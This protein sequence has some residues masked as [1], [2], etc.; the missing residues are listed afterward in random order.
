MYV[1]VNGARLYFD[2]EGAGLVPDGPRMREKPTLL[3]LHG[4][5]GFDHTIYK[6][7]FSAL[8]DIAQVIYLDH[9]G[10]GRSEG[11]LGR[12]NLPQWGDDVKGFCDALGIEKPIVYGASFGG[13]VAQSYMTRH[14]EHPAKVVLVSTAARVVYDEIFDAFERIGGSEARAIAEAYWLA[15]TMER[16]MAY[17][18]TCFPLYT[19]RAK[20]DPD[21]LRRA[22]LR[23]DVGL[24]FNGPHNE[25]GQID[26][27]ADLGY[28]KCPVLVMA[29][30]R[31][32]IMPMAFS[33]TLAACLP[34]HL[35]CFERFENCGHGVVPDNPERAFRLLREFVLN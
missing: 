14:P 17:L 2:V 5:P 9:R 21:A 27:R 16:R 3:L 7:A 30:D 22:I 34:R 20:H 31:D 8:A 12:S 10:N 6:P 28:V 35:V 11:T 33:E 4:G 25:Q 26:Y 32:P 29:G 13:W 1:T 19:T 15:P 24:A 23:H 18:E